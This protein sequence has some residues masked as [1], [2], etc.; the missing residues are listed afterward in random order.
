MEPT[1]H[2]KGMDYPLYPDDELALESIELVSNIGTFTKICPG[3][4]ICG[5]EISM[6]LVEEYTET[7]AVE[8]L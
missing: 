6:E 3:L 2:F 5:I 4:C 8:L 1:K 7:R